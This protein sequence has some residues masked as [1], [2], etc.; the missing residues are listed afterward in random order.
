MLYQ[1]AECH[2]E[3]DESPGRSMPAKDLYLFVNE[4]VELTD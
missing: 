4:N 2:N 3:G 1:N